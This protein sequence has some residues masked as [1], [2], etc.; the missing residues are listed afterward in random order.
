M[1]K[2]IAYPEKIFSFKVRK[3]ARYYFQLLSTQVS[4]AI[5]QESPH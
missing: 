2:C 3:K 1:D 5:L 4:M